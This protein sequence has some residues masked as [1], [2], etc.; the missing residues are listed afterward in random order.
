MRRNQRTSVRLILLALVALAATAVA[1]CGGDD[2]GGTTAAEPAAA[3]GSLTIYSGRS[4]SLIAPLIETFSK[5][6]GIAVEVRYGDSA[7][8]SA[9]IAEEG[10]ASPADVFLSQ[11]AGALGAL[12]DEERLAPLPAET[13]ALVD[14]RFR[15]P[16]GRWVGV[17]GRARVIAYSTERQTEDALPDSVLD[18]VEPAFKGKVG[19][20][21]TNASFQAFVSG[22]RIALGDDAARA[23]LEGLKANGA[24]AY[25]NNDLAVEA[26]ANGEVDM[27][28]VNH[29]YAYE[30]KVERPDLPVANHFLA[31][32]D[33]G[34]LVN[35]AGVGI[36][37][38]TDATAPAERF[39]AW[40][41]EAEAQAYFAEK[42]WEY[43]LIA[44]A[45]ADPGLPP[46]AELQGPE[47]SLGD[48]GAKLPSTLELIADVG[49][50]S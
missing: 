30:L 13:L 40:L 3:G 18:L 7:E 28:L 15:D 12:G 43:P 26:I 14:E 35:C 8:L 39:A 11:D 36:V 49:L 46:L 21:P 6:T 9:T 1:A 47:I 5:E 19:I 27:A 22:L 29:Y 41:L 48:L 10:D 50:A 44:G 25:D 42:T 45:A 33:P 34:A 32:G 23:W 38:G 4:E 2:D 17:S 24:K 20:A 37:A 16:D 31:A